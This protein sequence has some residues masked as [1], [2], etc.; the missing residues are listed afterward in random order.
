MTVRNSAGL[1]VGA[2]ALVALAMPPRPTGSPYNPDDRRTTVE[3][4]KRVIEAAEDSLRQVKGALRT[5]VLRDSV[6]RMLAAFPADA[7]DQL[8]LDQ[9]IAPSLRL[10]MQGTYAASRARLPQGRVALP[11]FVVLDTLWFTS[12]QWIEDA[13]KG[14][15]TCATIMHVAVSSYSGPGVARN[16]RRWSRDVRVALGAQFP[17]PDDFGLCAFEAAFGEPARVPRDWLRDRGWRPVGTGL[18]AS[19]PR[20]RFDPFYYGLNWDS[21]D[22]GALGMR[23]RACYAGRT[24]ECNAAAASVIPR[25][26]WQ[27]D[28]STVGWEGSRFWRWGFSGSIDLMN[29]LA[30]SMGPEKFAELWHAEDAPPDAY[31]RIT[32]VPMDTLAQRVLLAGRPPISFG[33]STTVSELLA[34]LLVAAFLAGLSTLSHPRNGRT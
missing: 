20:R 22:N 7:R 32:G 29:A 14:R 24:A 15:P 28:T 27:F 16:Q 34:V 8:I 3:R 21:Y 2:F 10:L 31:R 11:M 13:S 1:A 5:R 17:K 4:T 12:T 33:A 26:Q 19:R 18:S 30:A 23:Y 25:R 9:R 6:A